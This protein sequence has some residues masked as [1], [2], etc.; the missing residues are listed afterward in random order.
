MVKKNVWSVALLVAVLAAPQFATAT[1]IRVPADKPT[2]Q[3]G[4]NAAASHDTVLVS[5]G[6]YSG[7]GNRDIT[8]N[9]KAVKLISETGAENTII[10]CG[11]SHR[12]ALFDDY[13]SSQALFRGF[14]IKNASE[15]I[16][17]DHSSTTITNCIIGE[18]STVGIVCQTSCFPLIDSTVITGTS[19]VAMS[20]TS[21]NPTLRN[22]VF[23]DAAG[24]L[25]ITNGDSIVLT[26][27]RFTQVRSS[28]IYANDG[29]GLYMT[30]SWRIM[31]SPIQELS[32][33]SIRER[34]PDW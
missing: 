7:S 32:G 30:V 9:G 14:T 23:Q 34:I 3:A 17:L 28:L 12:G 26:S 24:G 1:T 4:I 18:N 29:V 6:T 8:F 2:I 10:D 33:Y 19:S 11:T 16:R 31:S 22:C 20:V 15:G 5:P 13:E 27:C 21:S 25:G